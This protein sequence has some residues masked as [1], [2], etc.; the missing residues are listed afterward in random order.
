VNDY[1]YIKRIEFDGFGKITAIEFHEGAE[2]K[3]TM[4]FIVENYLNGGSP[5]QIR[6]ALSRVFDNAR[7]KI[8]DTP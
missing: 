6:D 7:G 5:G 3:L 8:N 4:K 2:A 1:I